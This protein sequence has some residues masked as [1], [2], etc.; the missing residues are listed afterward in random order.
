MM[1]IGLLAV[2]GFLMDGHAVSPYRLKRIKIG[3]T[4]AEVEAALGRPSSIDGDEW[5]YA[6]P[7]W[8][9]VR[10]SFNAE[11]LVDYIDHDH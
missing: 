3:S 6:G 5:L 2:P 9:H 7:T 11:G 8:R 1:A 4:A 10:I